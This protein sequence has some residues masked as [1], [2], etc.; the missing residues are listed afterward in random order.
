MHRSRLNQ[1]CDGPNQSSRPNQRRPQGN[2]G[3]AS[4]ILAEEHRTTS[5]ILVEE[6]RPASPILAREPDQEAPRPNER[7][8]SHLRFGYPG[9][10]SEFVAYH[11]NFQ[12]PPPRVVPD[13]IPKR[14]KHRQPKFNYPGQEMSFEHGP[15]IIE[16]PNLNQTE[17]QINDK[18]KDQKKNHKPIKPEFLNIF[19][20]ELQNPLKLCR[21]STIHMIDTYLCNHNEEF[22]EFMEYVQRQQYD[23]SHLLDPRRTR[24]EE[25]HFEQ[26]NLLQNVINQLPVEKPIFDIYIRV[27][28]AR[29]SV[30][31]STRY[32]QQF[33]RILDSTDDS[34]RTIATTYFVRTRTPYLQ[35][36]YQAWTMVL[37]NGL[38]ET[39]HRLHEVNQ[40]SETYLIHNQRL[41]CVLSNPSLLIQL[42]LE[43]HNLAR[44][45]R[46]ENL[47]K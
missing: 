42:M 33:S 7:A 36:L 45:M 37:M 17:T 12:P 27:H 10:L 28:L 46:Q 14:D 6:H 41:M 8:D 39:Q 16:L 38:R 40:N 29:F 43:M 11:P 44:K 13:N 32:P 31:R 23:H 30:Q 24:R 25:R 20:L 2:R 9:A 1:Q 47:H 18:P 21:K 4:P 26:L 5:P 19:L 35:H 3:P 22:E 34:N 15:R